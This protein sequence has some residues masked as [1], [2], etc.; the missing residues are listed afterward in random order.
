MNHKRT[1][2]LSILGLIGSLRR[3]PWSGSAGEQI[4]YRKETYDAQR[5]GSMK[6]RTFAGR[7]RL[8][9][10]VGMV[11]VA[12]V[13]TL[14]ALP[15]V[16]PV[17]AACA[18]GVTLYGTAGDDLIFGTPGNDTIYGYGG[19]DQI[20][21]LGCDDRLYGGTGNN[22]VN[23]GSGD[24]HL[25]GDSGNDRVDGDYGEDI[26]EG[27]QG[28]D[29][30]IGSYGKDVLTGGHG[31]DNLFGGSDLDVLSGGVNRD[32]LDLTESYYDRLDGGLSPYDWCFGGDYYHDCP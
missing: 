23:G 28:N 26:I 16:Q 22:V 20:F 10:R 21:G 3:S 25:Y 29:L 31:D 27:G 1:F 8:R 2:A 17:Q 12:L 7:P 13:L 6:Q 9:R 14:A 15:G 5:E 30:L 19:N 4:S 18:R 24:D 32:D 11:A